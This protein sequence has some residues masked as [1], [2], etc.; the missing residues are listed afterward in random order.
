MA[1]GGRVWRSPAKEAA[2]KHT[3]TA[4][5]NAAVRKNQFLFFGLPM[6]GMIVIGSYVLS[7]ATQERYNVSDRRVSQMSNEEELGLK[8]DR[9]KIDLKEEYYK[10]EAKGLASDQGD[11]EQVRVQ[12]LPGE[13]D[14]ILG[15]Y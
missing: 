8:K 5:F 14:G 2:Y 10:L 3:F 9:R 15:K 7:F 4:R 6:M 12:R 1:L 11:W 13:L